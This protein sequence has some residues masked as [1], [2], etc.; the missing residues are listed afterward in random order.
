MITAK[1]AYNIALQVRREPVESKILTAVNKG[2]FCEYFS[3]D[4]LHIEVIEWLESLN[5]AVKQGLSTGYIV[6]WYKQK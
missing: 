5:Y 3:A 1:E 4:D 2:K 6:S